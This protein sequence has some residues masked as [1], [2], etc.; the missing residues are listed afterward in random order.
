M[1]IDH[2][3]NAKRYE[4]LHPG[5]AAAFAFLREHMEHPF[6]EG[7]HDIADGV[8]AMVSHYTTKPEDTLNWEGHRKYIDV[9]FLAVG[10]E[11]LGYANVDAMQQAGAYDAE[12]DFCLLTG[13]GL[14]VKLMP[15]TFA[16]LYPEDA[17]RPGGMN[18]T[19]CDVEKIVVK[20]ALD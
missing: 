5:F 10:E 11:L 15:G 18:G 6:S 8:Y 16:V 7:R 12:K 1:V 19:P 3:N 9:Q 20:V 4:V 17:H 14:P 2:L 13:K